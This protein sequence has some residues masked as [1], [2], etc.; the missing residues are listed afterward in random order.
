MSCLAK[1][2]YS[3]LLLVGSPFY[4]VTD[5]VAT[6]QGRSKYVFHVEQRIR[7]SYKNK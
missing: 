1:I 4:R 2:R 3:W 7:K 6:G 5:Y